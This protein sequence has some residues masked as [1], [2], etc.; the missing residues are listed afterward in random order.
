MNPN[1][2]P[3]PDKVKIKNMERDGKQLLPRPNRFTLRDGPAPVDRPMQPRSGEVVA[4]EPRPP[5][6]YER[7]EERAARTKS[8]TVVGQGGKRIPMRCG[9]VER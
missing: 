8:T 7:E 5:I 4:E 9:Q 6:G 3:P 1:R 2:A